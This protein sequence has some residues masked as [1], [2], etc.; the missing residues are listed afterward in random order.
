MFLT[1]FSTK[2]IQLVCVWERNESMYCDVNWFVSGSVN[3][4]IDDEVMI[5]VTSHVCVCV[6]TEVSSVLWSDPCEVCSG[7]QLFCPT[8]AHDRKSVWQTLKVTTLQSRLFCVK[9][10]Y[11]RTRRCVWTCVSDDVLDVI[12]GSVWFKKMSEKLM[13]VQLEKWKLYKCSFVNV[14]GLLRCCLIFA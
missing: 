13:C 11:Y 9:S 5:S 1:W 7:L 14:R 10:W 4:K 8:V 2:V 3:V 6:F 12:S